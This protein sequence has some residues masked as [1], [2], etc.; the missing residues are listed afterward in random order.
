[1][2]GSATVV[3]SDMMGLALQLIFC[4][5]VEALL[6]SFCVPREVTPHNSSIL[7]SEAEGSEP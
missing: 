3:C 4:V 6:W 5:F 2:P 1:M 7:V